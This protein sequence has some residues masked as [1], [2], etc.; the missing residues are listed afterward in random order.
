MDDC[1]ITLPAG[2]PW[3]TRWFCRWNDTCPLPPKSLEL[4]LMGVSACWLLS[5]RGTPEDIAAWLDLLRLEDCRFLVRLDV[6]QEVVITDLQDL[7]DQ[8]GHGLQDAALNRGGF[9]GA[10]LSLSMLIAPEY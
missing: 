4:F 5:F 10:E 6:G 9:P 2:L 7:L 1:R 8:F 3:L